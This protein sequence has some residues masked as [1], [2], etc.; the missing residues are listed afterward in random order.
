MLYHVILGALCILGLEPLGGDG[1]SASFLCSCVDTR[2]TFLGSG[3]ARVSISAFLFCCCHCTGGGRSV[4]LGTFPWWLVHPCNLGMSGSDCGLWTCCFVV[5]KCMASGK[6]LNLE[7]SVSSYEN[8][9]RPWL[10]ESLE[11]LRSRVWSAKRG[12]AWHVGTLCKCQLLLLLTRE[13]F[14]SLTPCPWRS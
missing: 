8:G 3:P 2:T 9:T 14:P 6:W 12:R 7:A 1:F 5:T 11:G 13:C 10:P 4:M